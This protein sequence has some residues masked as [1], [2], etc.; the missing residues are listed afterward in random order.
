MKKNTL[1]IALFSFIFFLIIPVRAQIVQDVANWP[2]NT[3]TISG[4][5]TTSGFVKDPRVDSNF[6]YDDDLAGSASLSDVI[7]AESPTID[8]SPAFSGGEQQIQISF[9]Y[10]FRSVGDRI[11]IE[12]WDGANW[13]ILEQLSG[14]SGNTD[15]KSCNGMQAFVSQPL[16]IASLNA[17]QLIGFKYR[18]RYTD[19]GGFRWGFCMGSP[20]LESI[21]TPPCFEVSAITIDPANITFDS[22]VIEWNDTNSPTPTNGW[23]IEYGPTGFT[24]GTGTTISVNT[25]PYTISGLMADSTYDV[26]I[27]AMCS[28]TEQSGW[29]GP[30]SFSTPT[31]PVGCGGQFVD[32]GGVNGNYSNGED[33]T[34]TLCPDNNGDVVTVQF[35]SFETESGFDDLSIYDGSDASATLLGV[36][37]GTNIPP[38][39]TSTDASGC[40]TFVFHSDGSDNRSG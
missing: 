36:F 2:N 32:S 38:T 26:Y 37:D 30:V 10:V 12:W 8:L 15:Y 22:A 3:W 18:I 21:A 5:Y 7:A 14:N 24:P 13:Q 17:A 19:N 25:H 6:S 34:T 40:L 27:R 35:L 28:N 4:A 29:T 39:F 16:T 23:E 20:T 11:Y 1:L 9:D 31:I 33:I